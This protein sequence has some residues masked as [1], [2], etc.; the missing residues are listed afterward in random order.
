VDWRLP[1]APDLEGLY[2]PLPIALDSAFARSIGVQ[3]DL[4]GAVADDPEDVLDRLADGS[5]RV[6]PGTVA[7]VTAAVIAGLDRLGREV[8]D[9][10]LPSGV[11]TV[12]G[13]VVDAG[14]AC[15][16]DQPWLA[17]VVPAARLVPGG[18]DPA[19][20]GRVLDLPMAS[21]VVST[22]V[23]STSNA[24]DADVPSADRSSQALD[25]LAAAA[26]AV[27]LR[28]DQVA[29]VVTPDL[30]VMVDGAEQIAVRWGAQGGRFWVDGSAE[31]CGRAVAW[32]AGAWPSRHR[33][34]AAAGSD[35][36]E[37]AEDSLE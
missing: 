33:A 15:V 14:E 9:I 5:R 17:Q 1:D 8:G 20:V 29:V 34:V 12:T 37:L 19:L 3:V 28:L 30:R 35:W 10:D 26:A 27:G 31:A 7:A 4:A 21:E 36:R 6:P 11:R 2:D 18:A 16:L 13:E 25:R 24:G 23:V 32:A 22:E